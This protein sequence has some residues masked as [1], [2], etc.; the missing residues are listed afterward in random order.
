MRSG[1]KF[2]IT[3]GKVSYVCGRKKEKSLR[4]SDAIMKKQASAL[5]HYDLS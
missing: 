5:C 1:Q 4:F 3:L 2:I